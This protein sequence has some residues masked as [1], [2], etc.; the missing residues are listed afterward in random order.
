VTAIE[1][2][3]YDE[4]QIRDHDGRRADTVAGLGEDVYTYD[5]LEKIY[6]DVY[7]EQSTPLGITPVVFMNGDFGLFEE[8]DDEHRKV[9]FDG[10]DA[11]DARRLADDVEWAATADVPEDAT[12]DPLNGFVEYRKSAA[13][14]IVGID[15]VG[16][17]AFLVPQHGEPKHLGDYDRFDSSPEDALKLSEA[18][19]DM[20]DRYDEVLDDEPEGTSVRSAIERKY[21][22]L[23]KRDGDGQW[24]DGIP[25]PITGD[26]LRLAGK[27]DLAGDEKL[28]SSA[29]IDGDA[30]G[31]RMALTERGGKRMLR[32][33]L[34]GEDYGKRNREEGTPAWD[35]SPPREP[36]SLEDY[37][38]LGHEFERLGAEYDAASPARQEEISARQEDIRE[39]LTADDTDFNG[40]AELDNFSM[41]RLAA[42]IRPAI[43]E[44]V[45]EAIRENVAL[46]EIEELEA[47]GKPDPERLAELRRIARLDATDFIVF[48]K[49]I[50]PG[51]RWGDVHFS[52]ELDDSS[53]GPYV[54]LGVMP[55]DAPDDWGDDQDWQGRFD[56]DETRKFLRLVDKMSSDDASRAHSQ[57]SGPAYQAPAGPPAGGQFAKGGGRVGAKGKKK[58][59]PRRPAAHGTAKPAAPSPNLS[60]DGKTGTGYGI[61]GGDARVRQL[62][63]TLNRLGLADS[64]GAELVLDGRYGPRTT[65]SVKKLQKALGVPADG[66][67]TP[68]LLKQAT[69]LPQ[70]PEKPRKRAAPRRAK[71][72]RKA[73]R[74]RILATVARALGECYLVDGVCIACDPIDEAARALT[75]ALDEVWRARH[76]RTAAGA[77]KYGLPIGSVIGGSDGVHTSH[78]PDV[79]KADAPKKAPAKAA[80]KRTSAKDRLVS[81]L[82]D[83]LDGK[84][85]A[86]PLAGFSRE[87]LRTVAKARGIHLDRGEP[88]DSIAGKIIDQAR[89]GEKSAE[90]PKLAKKTGA[91]STTDRKALADT[92]G[93]HAVSSEEPLAGGAVGDTR[94]RVY[95]DGSKTVWKRAPD[96]ASASGQHQADAEELSSLVA[97]SLGLRAPAVVRADNRTVHMAF[98]DGANTTAELD[99]DDDLPDS[100]AGRM[101]GLLDLLISNND[102]NTGNVLVPN[103][104]GSIV[105]IDHG[106]AF[107]NLG[108]PSKPG[109]SLGSPYTRPFYA[110]WNQS[111]IDNDLTPAD[112]AEI[113]T[114]LTRQ[115]A[116]FDRLNRTDWFDHMLARL[117]AIEPYAKGTTSRLPAEVQ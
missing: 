96:Y 3:R 45:D 1:L 15:D 76:V 61:K 10:I 101:M 107:R 93:Q 58:P 26:A 66:V 60:Y 108:D 46:D 87:Q 51:S 71:P 80:P 6:G 49:G 38:A 30:G 20:A 112:V 29:K 32:L 44:A 48:D 69:A 33:G 16:D 81:A 59:A 95:D 13:G 105:P 28:V 109:R 65:S 88:R 111:L 54:L 102:R 11:D 57:E 116:E 53:G 17:V 19:N 31:I 56:K 79:P 94:L 64:S 77:K 18:L 74:S 92:V 89:G 78:V 113:R 70:L 98:V 100:D 75:E 62:Q 34:G 7:D 67:V 117:D 97:Q 41:R 86:D 25:G 36:L 73:R 68:E 82:N 8:V 106:L 114:R 35:G 52:V 91:V 83:H 23:Q 43:A 47:S 110:V 90:A 24:S 40:T 104:G 37:D 39:Q 55:K 12:P 103:D 63:A 5:D 72:R 9:L 22:P 21:N 84:G 14:T 99:G 85:D 2:E 27:I 115:K 50:V 42:R 4:H